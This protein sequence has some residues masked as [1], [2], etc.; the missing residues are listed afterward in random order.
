MRERESHNIWLYHH[1]NM[2]NDQSD[3]KNK[4][5][6]LD[7]LSGAIGL[8][9]LGIYL[10]TR[11]RYAGSLNNWTEKLFAEYPVLSL[12]FLSIF[13]VVG[14]LHTIEEIRHDEPLILRRFIR[15]AFFACATIALVWWL[16]LKWRTMF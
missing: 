10:G 9:C 7:F 15:L 14:L 3:K 1:H 8:I 4:L 2:K 12:S 6:V 11:F 13:V 5:T 16:A